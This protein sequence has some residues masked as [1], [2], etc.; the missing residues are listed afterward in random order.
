MLRRSFA[1]LYL[2]IDCQSV[3]LA[4]PVRDLLESTVRITAGEK[5]RTFNRDVAPI[6]FKR[7]VSCHHDGGIAPFSLLD[8]GGASNHAR[9]IAIA[10]AERSMPPWQPEPGY[11]EFANDRRMSDKEVQT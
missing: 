2:A 9:E 7:C 8:H 4:E 11:G 3:I 5:R 10:T 6:L 1:F